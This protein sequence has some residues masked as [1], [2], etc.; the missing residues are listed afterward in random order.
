MDEPPFFT[1]EKEMDASNLG[2]GI[3]VLLLA[4]VSFSLMLQ[5]INSGKK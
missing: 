3:G 5:K 1:E 4:A 2:L